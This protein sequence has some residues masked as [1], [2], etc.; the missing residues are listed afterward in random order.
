MDGSGE[1]DARRHPVPLSEGPLEEGRRR[2]DDGE[3]D[4]QDEDE[5]CV[6]YDCGATTTTSKR[7]VY[8][9]RMVLAMSEAT[10]TAASEASRKEGVVRATRSEARCR[11]Y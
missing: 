5:T 10:A 8:D 4:E 3:E 7:G 6:M 2:R 1:A 9:V 11:A